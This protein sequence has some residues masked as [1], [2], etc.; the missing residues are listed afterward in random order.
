MSAKKYEK[1][2]KVQSVKLAL[3]VGQ[4]KAAKELGISKRT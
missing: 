1:D 3:E 4:T 2:Y